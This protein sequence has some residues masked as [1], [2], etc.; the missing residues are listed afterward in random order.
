[1][2]WFVLFCVL[3]VVSMVGMYI[4]KDSINEKI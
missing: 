2:I 3:F 1:M 4:V